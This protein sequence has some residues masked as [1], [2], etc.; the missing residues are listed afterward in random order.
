MLYNPT[1]VGGLSNNPLTHEDIRDGEITVEP[2]VLSPPTHMNGT[3]VHGVNKVILR[4]MER[5]VQHVTVTV[6]GGSTARLS[7]YGVHI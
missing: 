5:H 6:R 4:R 2:T 1:I 3:I 7:L